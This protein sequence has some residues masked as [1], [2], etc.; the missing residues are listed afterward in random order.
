MATPQ[1]AAGIPAWTVGDRLRKARE[2]AGL[3]QSDLANEIGISRASAVNYE[4]G[5]YEPHR[6]VILAWSDVCAVPF[7]W[8]CHGDLRPCD[9]K[10][11]GISAGQ[12]I[13]PGS[14]SRSNYMQSSYAVPIALRAA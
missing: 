13:A 8:L 6:P 3:K 7:E 9:F 4:S 11:R 10:P 1:P 12:G 14:R 2:H 5:R